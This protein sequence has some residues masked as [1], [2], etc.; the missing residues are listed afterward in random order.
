MNRPRKFYVASQLSQ[1]QINTQFGFLKD[2]FERTTNR[3]EAEFIIYDLSHPA[4]NKLI[5]FGEKDPV[6]VSRHNAPIMFVALDG[7]ITDNLEPIKDYYNCAE[8]P[9]YQN[10]AELL[11]ALRW[12]EAVFPF[13][14]DSTAAMINQEV[15]EML[16]GQKKASLGLK[17]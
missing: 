10:S 4:T 8:I 16:I 7:Q 9:I 14:N 17:P 3:N 12:F 13:Y 1:D 5:F 15:L 6:Y 2:C 11:N